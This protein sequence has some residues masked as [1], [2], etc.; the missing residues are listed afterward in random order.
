ML[1]FAQLVQDKNVEFAE[2]ITHR[3]KLNEI[4]EAFSLLKTGLAG[5]VMIEF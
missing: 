2:T 3:F 4:N 5:R 1:R